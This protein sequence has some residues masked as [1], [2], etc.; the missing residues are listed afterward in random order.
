MIKSAATL[1]GEVFTRNMAL[2]FT[3]Y[4]LKFKLFKRKE[5]RLKVYPDKA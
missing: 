5:L 1:L 4:S 2:L 3:K